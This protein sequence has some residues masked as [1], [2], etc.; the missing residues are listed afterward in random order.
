METVEQKNTSILHNEDID[1]VYLV[2]SGDL[3]L[4]ANQTCWPAQAEMEEQITQAFANEGITV[5]RAHSYDEQL[6]HGFIRKRL[7]SLD[8]Q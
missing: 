4:S 2:A 8:F 7:K 5:Q 1:T 6:K 3:R